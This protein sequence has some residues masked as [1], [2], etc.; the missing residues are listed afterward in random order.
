MARVEKV[1][2]AAPYKFAT[3]VLNLVLSIA[4][5]LPVGSRRI[6][7]YTY[8]VPAGSDPT[9]RGATSL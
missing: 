2:K 7:L 4:D 6:Q 5:N 8:I 1:A 9:P 3:G